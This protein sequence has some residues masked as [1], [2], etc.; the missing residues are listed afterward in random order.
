MHLGL[1]SKAFGG[2]VAELTKR[3]SLVFLGVGVWVFWS[4]VA[5]AL[6]VVKYQ[7]DFRGFFR[8]GS[9]F[10]HP[11][12]MR[13]I[14]RDSPWG[15]DGQFY[16]AL[17]TDPLLRN[18]E[19]QQALDSP[20]YRAQRVF[21]PALAW[22]LALGDGHAALWWYQAL[23]WVLGLGS[24]LLVAWWLAKAGA[25]VFWALPLAVTGG[26][27][28]SLTRATPDG[29]AAA[30]VLAVLLALEARQWGW[31]AVLLAAAALTKETSV[32]LMPAIVWWQW[33]ERTWRRMCAV[34]APALVAF[35]AWRLYLRLHLGFLFSKS[36]LAN[37]G[38]PIGWLPW[39]LREVFAAADING[40]EVLGLLALLATVGSL[41]L[42]IRSGMGLW[43][44]AYLA[45]GFLGLVLGPSVIT[46]AYA[47]SR[48]LLVL[49][50]LAVVLAAKTQSVWRKT[51]LF[52]VP[53]LW[54]LLGLALVRGEM[55]PQGGVIPVFKALFV[56]LAG[57]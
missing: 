42:A 20:S 28:A 8:L 25:S 33:R 26:L 50:F 19:T 56:H 57:L 10:H 34:L 3:H 49:P 23:V 30:L 55:I 44:L 40:V 21:L 16:A 48:V 35:F 22:L 53:V 54:G 29:A 38:L 27:V 51:A 11:S 31:A 45:F 43:E 12:L 4:A 1:S 32:L 37:L 7:G 9:E 46:E 14:P 52:A 17:A 2:K 15:Y 24:V 13:D 41:A 47:Y 5:C 6:A 18:P 36:E 39:K